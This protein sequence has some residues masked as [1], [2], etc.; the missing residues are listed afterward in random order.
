VCSWFLSPHPLPGRV[1]GS[2]GC[3]PFTTAAEGV[4]PAGDVGGIGGVGVTTGGMEGAAVCVATGG[5]AAGGAVG[6]VT[7]GAG[8]G[9]GAGAG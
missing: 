8:V 2:E 6:V 9:V 3:G 7:G 4:P 5:F 1:S